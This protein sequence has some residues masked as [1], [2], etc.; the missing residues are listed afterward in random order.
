M[1]NQSRWMDLAAGIPTGSLASA[2]GCRGERH[3]PA[4]DKRS[5]DCLG[6]VMSLLAAPAG[7]HPSIA[8][9]ATVL[10]LIEMAR[11][12]HTETSAC[13]VVTPRVPRATNDDSGALRTDPTVDRSFSLV[14]GQGDTCEAI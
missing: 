13:Q 5:V 6:C 9:V 8:A 3:D 12:H 11:L 2:A 14:N 7:G 4:G 10:G 1:F